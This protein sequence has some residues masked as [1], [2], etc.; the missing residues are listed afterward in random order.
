[1]KIYT[2]KFLQLNLCPVSPHYG[3]SAE[4]VSVCVSNILFAHHHNTEH[5]FYFDTNPICKVGIWLF[6]LLRYLFRNS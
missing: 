4:N 2:Q 1:M 6:Q 5:S 3:A